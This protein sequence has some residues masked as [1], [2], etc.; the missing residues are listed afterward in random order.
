M[1]IDFQDKLEYRG[2][3]GVSGVLGD[4]RN[5]QKFKKLF[6][7]FETRKSLNE[8]FRSGKCPEGFRFASGPSP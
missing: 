7:K 2:P 4:P 8:N 6:L 3:E 1:M 5:N